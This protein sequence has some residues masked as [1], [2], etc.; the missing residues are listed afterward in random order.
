MHR[1]WAQDGPGQNRCM[2]IVLFPLAGLLRSPHAFW[3]AACFV[4]EG[5]E[6][7]R[8]SEKHRRLRIR[9]APSHFSPALA[10]KC[11]PPARAQ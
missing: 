5:W 9:P 4:G 8:A 11:Y 7:W 10:A 6:D 2:C 3:G 1:S